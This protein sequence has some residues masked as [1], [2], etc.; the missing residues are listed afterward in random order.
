MSNHYVE[1]NMKKLETL[2]KKAA[3]CRHELTKDLDPW[4]KN[5]YTC[6][7]ADTE[8]EIKDIQNRIEEMLND[9]WFN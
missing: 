2:G 9:P 1:L 3:Y 7:L 4:A 5:E 8:V 6:I